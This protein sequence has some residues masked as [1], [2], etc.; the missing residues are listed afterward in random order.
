ML[1][2]MISLNGSWQL[3]RDPDNVGRAQRWYALENLPGAEAATVPGI[4]Q[5]TFPA[6]HGVF[7]Y[8]REFEADPLPTAD[9]RCLLRFWTVDYLAD[10]WVNGIHVGGHEGGETP[11]TLD[12]TNAVAPGATNRLAVRVLNPSHEPI[13]GI[14]LNET[15]HRNKYI[16]YR[17]GGSYDYGGITEPV[18]LILAP[19]V[20]VE[21]IFVQP[22]WQ[23]GAVRVRANLRNAAGTARSG[24]L[25]LAISPAA[26]GEAFIGRDLGVELPAGDTAVETELTV[27]GHHLWD[28]H[29][30]YL[31]RLSARLWS[32][33]DHAAD[34]CSVRFGFRD[35]RLADGYFRL[36]GRRI[37]VRSTHTGNHS[38]EGQI[39][40]PASAPDLLRRDLIYAKSSGFNM[41]RFISGMAH[42]Y[43]LDL[44][45]EIGLLVYEESLAGWLLADSPKMAERFDFSLREMILRDRNHP[46]LAIWGL[47]NET[48]DGP[49]FRHAITALPLIR[50][51][52]PG[53]LVLL[54]SGRWDC[55]Q[56]IGSA[57]NPGAMTWEHV[58][59]AEAPDAAPAPHSWKLGYPGGY[60][61][62]V[63][64]AHVYPGTPHTAETIR[65][66]RT[67]GH[68]TRP[69][70]LS[71]YGIGS[72]MNVLRELR[73]YEQKRTNPDAEDTV[74][75][76]S[77]AERFVA[78]WTRF[79]MDGV[80]AF[81]EDMLRESQR[82]HARQRLLGFDAIR[83][84]PQI[85][86]FN[87]TGMLD[88]GMTGEGLWTFWREWK[89]GIVDALSDGWAPVRWCLFVDPLHGYV[90]EPVTVEA[91]LANEDELA[92]GGY[93]VRLRIMGP[94]GVAWEEQAT[95]RIVQPTPGKDGPLAVPVYRGQV[96][97]SAPA[98]EYQF[99]AYI[100]RGAAPAGGCL[101][102]RL[103]DRLPAHAISRP[104][105]AWGPDERVRNWLASQGATMHDFPGSPAG[106]RQVILVG[107][108]SAA[109]AEAATWQELAR[110]VAAG[111]MAVF[112]APAA[113][114]RGDDPTGWLP[115][116][117]KGRVYDFNDWLY[118][119]EC[120]AKAHPIFEGLAAPGIMDWD[121]YG[122]VISR[123][124]FDGQDTPLEVM[125]AAFAL[126]YSIPGGYA[127]G[128]MVGAYRFG[129]GRF[130]FN[131]FKIL[132]NLGAH[133]AADRLLTNLVQY[134]DRQVSAE[135]PAPLPADFAAQ[136]AAIGY[137]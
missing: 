22:D 55:Q 101:R 127:S 56:A 99:A 96:T 134:A 76:R 61:E 17:N 46:S 39:L 33:S 137:A 37:F 58:W 43:Q 93:P 100:E 47:L 45:D 27:K 73:M 125:A 105:A 81:P 88:H 104:L 11:F 92:P 59:G 60:F 110:R 3:A 86:G 72:V 9:G 24:R 8:W 102:F 52:D 83:S 7:W 111:S 133:P 19:A 84:N 103:A 44:A 21:D 42:P 107:D 54:S 34:E 31:Y 65:F 122:P 82:L 38:P 129:A 6:C 69:V 23:T 25:H 40:P 91:V 94:A 118:H 106:Q 41:V 115:L 10:V 20:Q 108:L 71:E 77:M 95:L 57:S 116:Q 70:F 87:L 124:L 18:E 30:P 49:V 15:P 97:L 13:D 68:D 53:R 131:S 67:L 126:G 132:E 66:L 5:Q 121:Y 90:G 114:R 75:M 98:G 32:G 85:C 119:K 113:L 28:L 74:L 136:L 135:P 50:S 128:W 1:I 26:G 51:L 109:G 4:I 63:G 123:T 120:V 16:P 89:P 29:D 78:D 80:Y 36:N 12:I 130:V 112:L 2:T 79:G 64:D 62:R 48:D 117:K 35:L 14:V